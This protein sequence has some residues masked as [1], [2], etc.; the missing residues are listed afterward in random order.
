M[1]D[2]ADIRRIYERLQTDDHSAILRMGKELTDKVLSGRAYS[3]VELSTFYFAIE[4]ICDELDIELD[5]LDIK[6]VMGIVHYNLSQFWR[7]EKTT[8]TPTDHSSE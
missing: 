6:N 5:E 3:K 2:D 7:N 1:V 4:Q 8:H